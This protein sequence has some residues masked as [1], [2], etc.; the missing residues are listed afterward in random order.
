MGCRIPKEQIMTS[1]DVMIAWLNEHHLG[2]PVYL[3][4]T[5]ALE[6]SSRQGGIPLSQTP[7][8]SSSDSTRH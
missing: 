6:E 7:T 8:L 4:G 5:P 2:E 1:G 3:V